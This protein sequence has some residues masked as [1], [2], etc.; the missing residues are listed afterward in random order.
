MVKESLAEVHE[1]LEDITELVSR[2]WMDYVVEDFSLLKG[3]YSATNYLV[4]LL[5][6]PQQQQ[7]VVGD[8]LEEARKVVLKICKGYDLSAVEQQGQIAAY[9]H[10][11][12]FRQ[13]CAPYPLLSRDDDN[14][15]HYVTMFGSHPVMIVNYLNG[16]GGDLLIEDGIL[17]LAQAAGK[18]GHSLAAMHAI[19]IV[20]E[21]D[22]SQYTKNL[23]SYTTDGICFVGRH[24]TGDYARLFQ[25]QKEDY[26]R[27]HPFLQV[28]LAR[29]D[30][31]CATVKACDGL[32]NAVL[33]GDAFLDNVL[34][35]RVTGEG[36]VDFEDSC[37]GPALLDLACCIVGNCFDDHAR[38][39]QD[40]VE[41][42]IGNYYR[43]LKDVL[44][45]NQR[46]GWQQLL[47]EELRW[48]SAAMRAVIL[49]NAS[50]R[51]TNFNITLP[52]YRKSHGDKYYELQ[53]RLEYL[54]SKEGKEV[55]DAVLS[56]SSSLLV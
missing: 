35:D 45:D 21:T 4:K 9:L 3:G 37:V 50:W 13:C 2:W 43:S 38:L 54:E 41:A 18:I 12:G 40:A 32:R 47:E 26:I 30:D 42:M 46:E 1:T 29:Y 5:R 23:R 20:K 14:K 19:A 7:G 51:F 27:Q 49:L 25:D 24:L 16:V 39:Q 52:E 53:Q 8:N 36:F 33:H 10:D 17:T 28:Y 22:D 56:S 15:I 11:H 55:M 44:S 34:F 31:L 48:I 6:Q